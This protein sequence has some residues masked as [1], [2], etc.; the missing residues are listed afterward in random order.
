MWS[1]GGVCRHVKGSL[2]LRPASRDARVLDLLQEDSDMMQQ[3][4]PV[5][6]ECRTSSLTL[7]RKLHMT[8]MIIL[9]LHLFGNLLSA[10]VIVGYLWLIDDEK[11]E[12]CVYENRSSAQNLKAALSQGLFLLN[13][14]HC[15]DLWGCDAF[16]SLF[17]RSYSEN[18]ILWD[19]QRHTATVPDI[20]PITIKEE[21]FIAPLNRYWEKFKWSLTFG[22]KKQQKNSFVFSKHSN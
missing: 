6:L 14:L 3:W 15:W 4:H 8:N 2:P 7:C 5:Q 10:W 21:P 12:V 17:E 22:E 13:V 9:H 16:L 18:I 11:Q 19:T 1:T 20:N